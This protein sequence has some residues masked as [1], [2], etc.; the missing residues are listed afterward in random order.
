MIDFYRNEKTLVGCNTLLYSVEEFAEELKEMGTKFDTGLLKGAEHGEWK[1]I[2][3]AD[4]VEAYEKAGQRGA[5][6]FVIVMD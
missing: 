3:L 5:G 4:G 6:K 1:E 2:N